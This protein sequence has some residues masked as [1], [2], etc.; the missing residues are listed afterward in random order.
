[1]VEMVPVQ[2]RFTLVSIAYAISISV[3]GGMTPLVATLLVKTTHSY[4]GLVLYFLV[5]ALISL[6]AVYKVRETK[7]VPE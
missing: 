4:V 1:M 6:L 2:W 5:A 7:P 3:F